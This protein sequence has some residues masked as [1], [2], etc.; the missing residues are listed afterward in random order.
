MNLLQKLQNHIQGFVR[1]DSS[2]LQN[3]SRDE[4]I[5]TLTPQVV[6][7]P[8]SV[9]DIVT[10]VQIANDF[11]ASVV[12][13]GG[14]SGTTGA[15]L[16][17]QIVIDFRTHMNR[18]LDVQK[19]HAWV[20]PGVF[21]GELNEKVSCHGQVFGPDPGSQAYAC[22]G[23]VVGNNASGPH[24][25][26]Y[27]MTR[28]HVLDIDC[29]S[30]DGKKRSSKAM[31]ID[32]AQMVQSIKSKQ[33]IIKKTSIG[34]SK[35]S[36]GWYLDTFI[37]DQPDF[38]KLLTGS[39]GE[40]AIFEKIHLK[41]VDK[42]SVK[43]FALYTFK[44]KIQAAEFVPEILSMNPACVELIDETISTS[45]YEYDEKL[46]T[47]V[48]IENYQ[49]SLWV[50]W[51]DI[52]PQTSEMIFY[53]NDLVLIQKIW[54]LRSCASKIIHNKAIHKKPLRCIEDACVPVDRLPLYIKNI[55]S[56]FQEHG[57]EASVF[58]HIGNGHL[59]IN[60]WID[61]REPF[62][63]KKVYQLMDDFYKIVLSHHGTISGEHGDGFLRKKYLQDQWRD[64]CEL[65]TLVKNTMDPNLRFG[66]RKDLLFVYA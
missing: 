29:V 24:A 30:A 16:G 53:T 2:T 59:H 39:Q 34:V 66:S 52:Q 8:S 62:V 7:S 3:F 23:G 45:I 26:Q 48:G 32:Y 6:V 9:Q 10:V 36:S 47:S 42:P 51:L 41:L 4:S 20:E 25:L 56:L 49:V 22:I 33:D 50:E 27:G 14:G 57:I 60:P 44:N 37:S 38:A 55:E 19:D 61:V 31:L 58:G 21:L 13:R 35:N 18:I 65:F 54:N 11:D 40:L 46:C 5:F 28:D 17:D 1:S 64:R 15:S 43:S 12:L 63:E